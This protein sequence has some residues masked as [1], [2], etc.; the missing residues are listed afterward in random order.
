ML[1]SFAWSSSPDTQTELNRVRTFF[2]CFRSFR[3]FLASHEWIEHCF[4]FGN[5]HSACS[6]LNATVSIKQND[7]NKVLYVFACHIA[8]MYSFLLSPFSV[9]L[10]VFL[11]RL[12]TMVLQ[13]DYTWNRYIASCGRCL[14]VAIEIREFEK[15][16]V[17]RNVK[18]IWY[19]C[20][21]WRRLVSFLISTDY[22]NCVALI[23]QY[24]AMLPHSNGKSQLCTAKKTSGGFLQKF[25]NNWTFQTLN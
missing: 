4:F 8:I 11:F 14:C 25:Y 5:S 9:I 1:C 10:V 7:G 18:C 16:Y 3:H 2:F 12:L 17:N 21:K 13:F 15:K 22:H 19:L 24:A 6:G 20:R 23:K